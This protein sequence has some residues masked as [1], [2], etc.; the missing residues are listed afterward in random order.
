MPIY[1][2]LEPTDG[3]DRPQAGH[4]RVALPPPA[5]SYHTGTDH[6]IIT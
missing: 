3:V 5:L 6:I 1:A 2:N 4:Q